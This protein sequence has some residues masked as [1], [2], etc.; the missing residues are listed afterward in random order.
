MSTQMEHIGRSA[1]QFMLRMPEGLREKV[2]AL[3]TENRRSMNAELVLI[4][5]RAVKGVEG[6][7]QGGAA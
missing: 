4:V 1:S 5:E 3:A 7:S 6:A 2:K